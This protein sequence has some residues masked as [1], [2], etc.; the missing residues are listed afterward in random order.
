MKKIGIITFQWVGNNNYGAMLQVYA[1]HKA[2]ANMGYYSEVINYTPSF[3]LA[4]SKNNKTYS[5]AC[6]SISGN[7]KNYFKKVFLE[8]NTLLRQQRFKN[9]HDKHLNLSQQKYNSKSQLHETPPIYDIYITGSDQVWNPF[10]I[11]NDTSYFLTF[12]PKAKTRISYAASFG[13]S[14]I[15]DE[16]KRPFSENLNGINVL[17]V[18]ERQ[19]VRIIKELTNQDATVVLDPTFLL[20]PQDWDQISVPFTTTNP[21]I[22]GYFLQPNEYTQKLSHHIKKET[23][24]QLVN[25]G[26]G[27]KDR[28]DPRTIS[29]FDAGPLE[30]IGLVQGASLIVTNSFHGMAFAINHKKPFLAVLRSV[31][32]EKSMNSRQTNLLEQFNLQ[33]RILKI[34][35]P[36]PS[37]DILDANYA[38]LNE[39]LEVK[40]T[41]SVKFLK[42]AIDQI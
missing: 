20:T 32:D 13:V 33:S 12:A 27:L 38:E 15:P 16:F 29:I 18:R 37:S 42:E 19:G 25:I 36:F 35:A 21:Y 40:R 9:F 24:Y 28:F 3:V 10:N 5:P 34:N 39:V 30:F 2:L 8:K 4:D 23:G 17:S 7:V 11:S 22:L 1:L 26:N 31:D 41:G 6:N 14:H